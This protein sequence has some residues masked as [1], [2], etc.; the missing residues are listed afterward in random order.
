MM[1]SQGTTGAHGNMFLKVA[2]AKY[3]A[4][5]G[6]IVPVNV[7][8]VCPFSKATRTETIPVTGDITN[9]N[10]AAIDGT[11]VDTEKKIKNGLKE[12][13]IK[14]NIDISVEIDKDD[15]TASSVCI[16]AQ[17]AINRAA[18]IEIEIKKAN[19]ENL[20]GE[21]RGD[22]SRGLVGGSLESELQP[23]LKGICPVRVASPEEP[24]SV[25]AE[26]AALAS[27]H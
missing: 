5:Q 8:A 14:D 4:S 24:L 1:K 9:D 6:V 13:F 16:H 20:K 22:I 3:K 7:R 25:S 10:I 18:E 2:M 17:I 21:V 27:S 19:V 26:G 12:D 11:K 15:K 23:P